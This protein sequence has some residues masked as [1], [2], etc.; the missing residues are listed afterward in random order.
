MTKISED[1]VRHVALLSRLKFDQKEVSEFTTQLNSILEY[2]DQLNKLDTSN[3][4]P[5]SH[6]V[7]MSNVFREDLIKEPLTVEQALQNAPE[8]EA[9]CFK[10]PRIIQEH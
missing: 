7:K 3:V 8:K 2:M 9:D 6:P 5:T 10:V 4:E 1:M